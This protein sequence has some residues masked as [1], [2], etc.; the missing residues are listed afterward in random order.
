MAT[1]HH[2][3]SPDAPPPNAHTPHSSHTATAHG[4]L[5]LSPEELRQAIRHDHDEANRRNIRNGML[6]LGGFALFAVIGGVVAWQMLA[7]ESAR[8]QQL[9]DQHAALRHELLVADVHDAKVAK[10]VL[11]RLTATE[12]E[13]RHGADAGQFLNQ[14][15]KLQAFVADA[16]ALQAADGI[17]RAVAADWR[18]GP[19]SPAAWQSLH[20]RAHAAIT[21]VPATATAR[22]DE[23]A[24]QA[25]DIDEAWFQSLVKAADDAGLDHPRALASLSAA[26]RV[27]HDCL[28]IHGDHHFAT[29]WH[30]L[31]D[32]IAL[33]TNAAQA[34]VF[35]DAAIAAV[36]W[37]DLLPG[38][39]EK[40]WVTSSG[41]TLLRQIRAD[42]LHVTCSGDG[43]AGAVVVLRHHDWQACDLAMELQLDRGDATI[44]PRAARAFDPAKVGALR[45]AAGPLAG[46]GDGAL[47]VPAGTAVPVTLR[48]V[49]DTMTATIAEPTPQRIEVRIPVGERVGSLAIVTHPGSTLVL[50]TL[51]VRKL[52]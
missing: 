45:L 28:G 4:P 15:S 23:L 11:E 19:S 27:A 9:A 14:R 30:H 48:L 34:A 42:G 12:P 39:E 25:N 24:A 10:H 36:P 47:Q 21:Q 52:V 37:T 18:A 40:D 6:W 44:F 16:T 46:P 35:D 1:S 17:A 7:A 5:H 8:Q 20:D 33:R 32:G 49:G 3:P 38:T 31:Q 22:R 26:Q 29:A 2:S 41:G 51:R 13:W 50:H 43:H